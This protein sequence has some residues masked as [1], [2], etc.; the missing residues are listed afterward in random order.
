MSDKAADK[1]RRRRED[2]DA[3]GL[4]C[5]RCRRHL[6]RHR[7]HG[8]RL[9]CECYVRAGYEPAS[10]HPECMAAAAPRR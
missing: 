4:P 8:T 10:W 9:C 2:V 5:S 3:R 1:P 6:A 7:V